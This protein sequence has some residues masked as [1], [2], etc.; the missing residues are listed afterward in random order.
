MMNY[1]F[2][3]TLSTLPGTFID[4]HKLLIM[5][6]KKIRYLLFIGF[7][8]YQCTML[9][10]PIHD[11]FQQKKVLYTPASTSQDQKDKR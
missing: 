6:K 5:S 7:P 1:H 8:H 2:K 9:T 11:I 3:I 4:E 10:I